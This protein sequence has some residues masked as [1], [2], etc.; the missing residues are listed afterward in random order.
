MSFSLSYLLILLLIS[1][2]GRRDLWFDLFLFRICMLFTFS[3]V[4]FNKKLGGF[5]L[6]VR[7]FVSFGFS[8]F[9]STSINFLDL[10]NSMFW[11][12]SGSLKYV[13]LEEISSI[14]FLLKF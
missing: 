3:F 1:I 9:S 12:L 11:K 5:D 8:S 6:N 10:N 14:C 2:E 13:G 7:I 4:S